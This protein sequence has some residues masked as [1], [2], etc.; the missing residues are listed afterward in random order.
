MAWKT[1][2]NRPD[3]IFSNHSPKFTEKTYQQNTG[4]IGIYIVTD[5]RALQDTVY[6]DYL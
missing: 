2:K 6:L 1:G 3:Y 5:K 4:E